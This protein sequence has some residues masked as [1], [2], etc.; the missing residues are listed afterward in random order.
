MNRHGKFSE[1][2]TNEF[3]QSDEHKACIGTDKLTPGELLDLGLAMS[4]GKNNGGSAHIRKINAGHTYLGQFIDHDI[5][6]LSLTNS[7][8]DHASPTSVFNTTTYTLDLSSLYGTGY[9]DPNLSRYPNSAQLVLSPTQSSSGV[10]SSGKHL[11]LPRDGSL[12]A[13][14][15]DSRNDE[16]LLIAQLHVLFAKAHNRL[17][18]E[19]SHTFPPKETFDT[20]RN[21]LTKCYKRIVVKDYLKTILLNKVWKFYFKDYKFDKKIQTFWLKNDAKRV[22]PLEFSGAAFRFGHSMVRDFYQINDKEKN[23]SISD[24]FKF[25]GRGLLG[26][27]HKLPESKI[28][29]WNLFFGNTATQHA[30]KIRP[31]VNIKIPGEQWPVNRLAVRNLLRSNQLKLPT[32]QTIA[33]QFSKCFTQGHPLREIITLIP[34]DSI[35]FGPIKLPEYMARIETFKKCTPLW[36]YVLQESG[37]HKIPY[38]NR[39][40][41]GPMGSI[42]IAETFAHILNKSVQSDATIHQSRINEIDDMSSLVSYANNQGE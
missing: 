6:F 28:V 16:N 35:P 1:I 18:N 5:S 20:A 21:L 25:T 26:G 2:I 30:F 36:Y 31:I 14:I 12:K 15:P 33:C 38:A 32:A 7:P 23:V 37:A 8:I 22:I 9:E 13:L 39:G 4:D 3:V 10:P 29:D 42:I 40:A 17:V 41:L 24:L 11:D 27:N 19:F 34:K